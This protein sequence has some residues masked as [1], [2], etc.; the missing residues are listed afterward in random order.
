MYDPL[1]VSVLG[2]PWHASTEEDYEASCARCEKWVDITAEALH[3]R[4][5]NLLFYDARKHGHHRRCLRAGLA[6]CNLLPGDRLEPNVLLPDVSQLES[7]RLPARVLFWRVSCE[8]MAQHR[9]PLFAQCIGVSLVSSVCVD[10]LHTLHLGP[11][12]IWCREAMWL[13]LL[14]VLGRGPKAKR[15]VSL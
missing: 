12:L 5:A 9:C 7:L 15:F 14:A 3:R 2:L 13:L 10:L 8:T 4:I 11:M 1:G 6:D